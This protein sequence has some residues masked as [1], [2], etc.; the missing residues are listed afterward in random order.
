MCPV[1]IID[2]DADEEQLYNTQE[3]SDVDPEGT[4]V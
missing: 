1:D 3:Q 4:E 2:E